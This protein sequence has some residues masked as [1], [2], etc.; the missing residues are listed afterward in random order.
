MPANILPSGIRDNYQRG[1][2]GDFLKDKIQDGSALSIVSAYFTIYAYE[3][4]KENLDQIDHL[5]FLF[6][7]PRFIQSLDPEKTDKKAYDIE[8]GK[9]HLTNRLEQR[10][11]ARECAAWLEQKTE[12]KSVK[13]PGFLYCQ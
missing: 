10:R 8:D 11:V 5:R 1:T 3:A 13:Q 12:I 6:G 7:E 9:L 2:V 4:L